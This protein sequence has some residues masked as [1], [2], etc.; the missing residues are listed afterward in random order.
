MTPGGSAVSLGQRFS[1]C[2]LQPKS[3]PQEYKKGWISGMGPVHGPDLIQAQAASARSGPM[4]PSVQGHLVY[5]QGSPW[6]QKFD[7]AAEEQQLL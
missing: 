4:V 2:A 3:G 7:L 1:T 6:G 5:P